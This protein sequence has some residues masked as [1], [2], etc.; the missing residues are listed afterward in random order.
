[1]ECNNNLTYYIK[2][3]SERS[4]KELREFPIFN[5]VMVYIKDKVETNFPIYQALK[6]LEKILPESFMVDIDCIIFGDFKEFQERKIEA[7]YKDGAIYLS[8]IQK[9]VGKLIRDVVHEVGH[10]LE[11]RLG[12]DLYKDKSI[13]EEFK[14]KRMYLYNLIKD[15]YDLGSIFNDNALKY[16]M[17]IRYNKEFDNFL[18]NIIGYNNLTRITRDLFISPYS[19]TSIRE[20]FAIGFERYFLFGFENELK[21]ICPRLHEKISEIQIML[22]GK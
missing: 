13:Q 16:F 20:Y 2:E 3:S 8:P 14:S 9:E 12:V 22:E 6:Q 11:K 10:S 7:F 21:T 4:I 18:Y 1:M 5:K 17:Y 19:I 15:D